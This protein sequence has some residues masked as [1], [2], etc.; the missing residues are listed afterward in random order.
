MQSML[1]EIQP[2]FKFLRISGLPNNTANRA[3]MDPMNLFCLPEIEVHITV[4]KNLVRLSLKEKKI[5]EQSSKR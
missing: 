1:Y 3:K 5:T 4:I 2:R